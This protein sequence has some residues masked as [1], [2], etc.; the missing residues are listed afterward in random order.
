MR[1]GGPADNARIAMEVPSGTP[2]A[3]RDIVL[4]NA[5]AALLITGA[6]ATIPEAIVQAAEAIDSG[7][8]RRALDA[9]ISISN[10]P[11]E[12]ARA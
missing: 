11:V 5:G 7:R 10:A 8:A 4:F 9:M 2:G 12:A 6:A 1:G 3:A